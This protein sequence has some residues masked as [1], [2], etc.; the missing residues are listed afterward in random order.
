MF[1]KFI[2]SHPLFESLGLISLAAF[3]KISL[4]YISLVIFSTHKKLN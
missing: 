1:M 2:I 4:S 3:E